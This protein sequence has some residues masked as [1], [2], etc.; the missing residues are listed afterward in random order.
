MTS[1]S[2]RYLPQPI[3]LQ[4]GV[5]E[6]RA[7]LVVRIRLGDALERIPQIGI[8]AHPLVDREVALEHRA[9][10][11]EGGDAGLDRRAPRLRQLLRRRRRILPAHLEAAERGHAEPAE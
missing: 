9:V 10:R 2:S 11:A 5:V 8:A 1:V 6:H 4:C 7:L 3:E